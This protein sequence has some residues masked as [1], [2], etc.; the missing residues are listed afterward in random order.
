MGATEQLSVRIHADPN[1][2]ISIALESKKEKTEIQDS[3][4]SIWAHMDYIWMPVKKRHY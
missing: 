1:G 2:E 3:M 4:E